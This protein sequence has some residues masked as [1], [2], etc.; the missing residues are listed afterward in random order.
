MTM[1]MLCTSLSFD[2][3]L[4]LLPRYAEERAAGESVE[5]SLVTTL[6]QSGRVVVVSATV[7]V[8]AWL[9]SLLLP[10]LLIALRTFWTR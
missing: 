2:Y 9:S 7:L 10:P 6:S 3:S 8:I 4:F 1:L 5:Q